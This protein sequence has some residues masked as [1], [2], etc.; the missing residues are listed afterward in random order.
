MRHGVR[1]VSRLL[2]LVTT[3]SSNV[4]V[5][6]ALIYHNF[7]RSA[8]ILDSQP[9]IV[10]RT[11]VVLARCRSCSLTCRPS[12]SMRR[13]ASPRLP[14]PGFA[15]AQVIEH[16]EPIEFPSIA[17]FVA[18]FMRSNAAVASLASLIEQ[19]GA[20]EQVMEMTALI[21]VEAKSRKVMSDHFTRDRQIYKLRTGKRLP[22]LG[23][24]DASSY[25]RHANNET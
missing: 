22:R 10:R 8:L 1:S 14:P 2:S 15:N 24:D 21:N 20:G 5:L 12:W 9:V 3:L 23:I 7:C 16:T 18:S 17:Q 6:A 19:F 13:P 25:F 11:F 4:R